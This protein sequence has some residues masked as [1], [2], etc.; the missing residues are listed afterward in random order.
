MTLDEAQQKY[1]QL[2]GWIAEPDKPFLVEL[3]P[4]IAQEFPAPPRI[5]EVGVFGGGTTRGL[6][7]LTGGTVVG[8]D[9]WR[10]VH[11]E[12]GCH[13]YN[14]QEGFFWHVLKDHGQ[15][16]SSR[17]QLIVGNSQ[18]V[19][20][21]WTDPIDILFVDGDHSYAGA[22]ADIQHFAPHV[23]VGGYCLVDDWDMPEVRRAV[24]DGFPT[25]DWQTIRMPSEPTSKILVLKK[26]TPR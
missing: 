7:A 23:V 13:G 25:S 15:D 24:V 18:E 22:L 3:L 2:F 12:S 26:I 16:F 21:R 10:D 5:V 14:T 17:A 8:I 6:L 11:P 19:G 1:G 4:Q 9:N 20:A